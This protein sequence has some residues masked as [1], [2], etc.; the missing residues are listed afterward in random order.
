LGEI[1]SKKGVSLDRKFG[2]CRAEMRLLQKNNKMPIRS[3]LSLAKLICAI[4]V[5]C[6]T[7]LCQPPPDELSEARQLYLRGEFPAAIQ[8]YRS[9][10]EKTPGSEEAQLGL[11][12]SSWKGDFVNDA[13]RFGL[14]ALDSFPSSASIHAAMGDVLFRMGKMAEARADYQK[15]IQLDPK[16]AR[17]YFGMDKIYSFNFFHKSANKMEA[18][19]YEC[20]PEDPEI[21]EAYASQLPAKD[22]IL[23]LEKYLRL[24]TNE[25][26]EKRTAAADRITYYKIIGDLK[27]WKISDPPLQGEIDLHSVMDP[28]TGKTGY[29]ISV[30]F[31][32]SKKVNLQLDTGAHG[33][34]IR[35][36]VMEKLNLE[37]LG[38]SHISGIGDSG[39]QQADLALAQSV[40]IGPLEFHTCPLR[41]TGK[42]LPFDR[43]GIIGVDVFEQFLITLNLPNN[44]L[45]FGPL[46]EIQGISTD[47]ESWKNLD[48]TIPPDLKSFALMG[49]WGNLVIP[50][51][52]NQKKTGFFFLDT[53]AA[54]NVLSK[55][56]AQ[57]LVSLQ[58]MGKTYG[59]LSGRTE[60]YLAKN[61]SVQIG[62]LYQENA[63]IYA[64][65]LK[66]M[67][68]KLGLEISGLLGYPM[69]SNLVITLDLR[70]GLIDFQYPSGN[71]PRKN[72]N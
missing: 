32:G 29:S 12:R 39:Q 60:T 15:A 24:A 64:I 52:I 59:G 61:V 3:A 27:T 6:S 38:P 48:R 2:A 47:P 14:K 41:V 22:K 21:I 40:G 46:P 34:L 13:Y 55:A 70:D 50:T 8:K 43:D 53:G 57:E 5:T 20:D 18:M 25:L 67:S 19:A 72:K 58:D 45:E 7:A 51:I 62:R 49:R 10:I 66:D 36:N 9:V 65:D 42:R 37:L 26:E 71:A 68:Q 44:K 11:I 4:M 16:S 1:P 23:L 35:H 69:L 56:I 33:I 30:L 17:A 28:R 63:R 31:N 54:T